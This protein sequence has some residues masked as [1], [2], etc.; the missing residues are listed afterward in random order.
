LAAF[1]HWTAIEEGTPLNGK[2]LVVNVAD[3]MCLRLKSDI[4][5]VNRTFDISIHNHAFGGDGSIDLSPS[6]DHEWRAVEFAVN[7]AIDL[8]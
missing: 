5:A 6:G 8:D 4:T 3:D 7:L 1:S 2:R